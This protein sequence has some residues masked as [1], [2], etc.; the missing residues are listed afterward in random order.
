MI[1]SLVPSLVRDIQY[2]KLCVDRLKRLVVVPKREKSVYETLERTYSDKNQKSGHVKIQITED[3]FQDQL[4]T[5]A[6]C[7]DIGIQELV[8]MAMRHYPDMPAGPVNEDHVRKAATKADLAV[9]YSIAELGFSL[10]LDTPQVRALKESPGWRNTRINSRSSTPFHFTSGRG[11][12]NLKGLVSPD[13]EC[14]KRS[15]THYCHPIVTANS[16]IVGKVLHLSSYG[17][18]YILPSLADQ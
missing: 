12:A 11:V 15:V 4:G 7:V 3:S 14:T 6:D 17:S 16:S 18:L 13:Q 5:R 9:L 10:G 2:L 1:D 8:A